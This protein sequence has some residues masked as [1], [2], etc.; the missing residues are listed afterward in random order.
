[1]RDQSGLSDPADTTDD[2][3][4]PRSLQRAENLEALRDAPRIL[5]SL[6]LACLLLQPFAWPPVGDGWMR[7][8]SHA[9]CSSTSR[10]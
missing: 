6:E 4:R 1:M 7:Y 3:P 10:S 2:D 9:A 5:R 8:I